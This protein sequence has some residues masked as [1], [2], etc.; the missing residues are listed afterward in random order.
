VN[1]DWLESFFFTHLKK[2][3][4][5]KS[6]SSCVLYLEL[7]PFRKLILHL[8]TWGNYRKSQQYRTW[9]Y[10]EN[11]GRG[12]PFI[13]I[14]RNPIFFNKFVKNAWKG[15]E[16]WISRVW[17]S[18]YRLEKT[19]KNLVIYINLL[20]FKIYL[21]TFIFCNLLSFYYFF[22]FLPMFVGFV[23]YWGVELVRYNKHVNIL[24]L[25]P[26]KLN[27]VGSQAKQYLFILIIIKPYLYAYTW[28][29]I[30]LQRKKQLTVD[31][32]LIKNLLKNIFVRIIIGFSI[33][34]IRK[35]NYI[36]KK[37]VSVLEYDCES[38]ADAVCFNLV[39]TEI[40][41]C[42][43]LEKLRI[44]KSEQNIW[45]FNPNKEELLRLL[46]AMFPRGEFK[47][48][49]TR[50]ERIVGEMLIS[51]L[52]EIEKAGD[53]LFFSIGGKTKPH[54]GAVYKIGRDEDT[55]N[56]I[57]TNFTSKPKTIGLQNEPLTE[58]SYITPPF[59][60][61]Q[62]EL[63]VNE[64]P[65]LTT[66]D[67]RYIAQQLR[68]DELWFL[69]SLGMKE[70]NYGIYNKETDLFSIENIEKTK[71]YSKLTA[72]KKLTRKYQISENNS[73]VYGIDVEFEKVY[74]TLDDSSLQQQQIAFRFAVCELINNPETYDKIL[75]LAISLKLFN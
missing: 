6:T 69:A 57:S 44:F 45:N 70:N 21:L 5:V 27:I 66:N 10:K 13:M 20:K 75:E 52:K 26:Q 4:N 72:L 59:L 7:R 33:T 31:Y 68:I 28:M 55:L 51:K 25:K 8:T 48:A 71:D 65:E 32:A 47:I 18:N 17:L 67:S 3:K 43:Q 24:E 35:A 22:I 29:Y 42:S 64:I 1:L 58:K 50:S 54:V 11:W 37:I 41:E 53:K 39:M 12:V 74:T 61:K 36:A 16:K 30:V 60:C 49:E 15:E 19:T 9:G 40:S 2:K 73:L 63:K 46:F 38:Y 34:L 62:S 14:Y 56:V 23:L